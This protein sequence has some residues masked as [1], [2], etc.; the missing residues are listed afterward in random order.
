MVFQNYVLYP[1]MTVEENLNFSPR[2]A[3]QP[4][5]RIAEQV[6]ER[7]GSSGWTNCWGAGPSRCPA[8]TAL[9]TF[10]TS[11]TGASAL[12]ETR[13]LGLTHLMLATRSGRH[14]DRR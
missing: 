11:L 12:I 2:I 10:L 14:G 5:Q 9:F 6:G 8:A 7:R 4:K 1:H 3:H 13:R